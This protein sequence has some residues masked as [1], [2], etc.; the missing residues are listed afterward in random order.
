MNKFLAAA[1]AASFPFAALAA[2]PILFYDSGVKLD[3]SFN[4][5][6]FNGAELFR[7]T[8]GEPYAEQMLGEGEDRVAL[9]RRAAEAG[10]API[11]ALGFTYASA[12]ETVAREFPDTDFAIVDMVVPLPNV[13]SIVFR[14]HEGSY[15]MGQLAAMRSETG[16]VGFVGGMDIPVIRKFA[17]GYVGGAKA[18][19]PDIDVKIEM[20]GTTPKAFNDPVRGAEIAEAQI[21]EGADVI[22]H[23]S[24]GTGIGVLNAAAEAGV[25]G[26][27]VD[28]NQNGVAPGSV[29]T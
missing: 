19:N 11:V 26:I 3:G 22:F 9:L 25:L 10:H 16:T 4:E 14:E 1:F 27:G 8:T 17:C 12:V 21:A 29:L 15:L 18:Y 2:E 23:A 6:G 7:E 5:S 20:T 28:M 13:R 24:G